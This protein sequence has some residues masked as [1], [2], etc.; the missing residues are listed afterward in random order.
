MKE[1]ISISKVKLV[2]KYKETN[3]AEG[4]ECDQLDLTFKANEEKEI[5]LR[6]IPHET[7]EVL[8]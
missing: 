2:C 3:S 1:G 5:I 7:G 8:I 4:L 6:V